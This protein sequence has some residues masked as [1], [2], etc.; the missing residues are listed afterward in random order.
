MNIALIVILSVLAFI[1]IVIIIL[2]IISY[3]V[4]YKRTKTPYC[5]LNVKDEDFKFPLSVKDKYKEYINIPCEKLS[6]TNKR[7]IKL[8]GELRRSENQKD[9]EIKTVIIFSHG[10][11]SSGDND[12][13][14]FHNFQLKNYDL[15]AIDHEGCGKSEGKHS[16]FGI[17]EYENIILWVNKINEL[18]NHKVN[19]FL[20]GVSMGSNSVLLTCDKKM[21]NVKGIIGDCGFTSTYDIVKYLTK[22]N[23]VAFSVCLFNSFILKRNIFKYSTSKTVSNSLYPILFIHGKEDKFVPFFMSE[24]NNK[25]CRSNHKFIPVDLASHA[26]SYLVNPKLY[27]DEFNNFISENI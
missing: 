27:E 22:L 5:V 8:Y 3:N 17:Y 4:M 9:K 26:M 16:G 20:H 1:L 11:Q 21:E 10:Y 7:N 25:K 6:I 19:I 15:L 24:K 13:P 2:G 12:V 23:C 14:L 18:Y